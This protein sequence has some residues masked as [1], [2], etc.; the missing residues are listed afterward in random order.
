MVSY[1]IKAGIQVEGVWTQTAHMYVLCSVIG[2]LSSLRNQNEEVKNITV[3]P[4][5]IKG[6]NSDI[7]VIC[8]LFLVLLWK[9]YEKRLFLSARLGLCVL[10]HLILTLD[11]MGGATNPGRRGGCRH[12][13]RQLKV[14]GLGL[15]ACSPAELSPQILTLWPTATS[16][17]SRWPK[18]KCEMTHLT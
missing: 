3:Q 14:V 6:W 4:Q 10:C 1:T 17:R 18:R 5:I 16:W 12:R 13:S 8:F 7:S 9:Y 15:S 11:S 2:K